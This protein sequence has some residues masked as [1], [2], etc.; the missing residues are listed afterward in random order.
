[1][2][3]AGTR[4]LAAHV[5]PQA[6]PALAVGS[7]KPKG[8]VL[9]LPPLL[10]TWDP[11]REAEGSID[12][13]SL[14]PIYDRLADRILP[15]L[16][17]RMRRIRFVTAMCVAASV[18][19]SD[20]ED[21][22]VAKDEVTPPWLVF[23]WFVVE[24]LVRMEKDLDDAAGVPGA[25]KVRSALLQGRPVSHPSYLKTPRVFGFS[26]IFRRF[27]TAVG[28][29]TDDLSLDDGGYALLRAWEKD[30]DLSGFRDGTKATPG[31]RLREDLRSAVRAGM[32]QGTTVR[33][34]REFWSTLARVLEPGRIKR[35]ER[36]VLLARLGTS[37]RGP[38]GG[39]ADELVRAL[40][41]RGKQLDRTEE[42]TF[43][44]SV[45]RTASADLACCLRALDSF[46]T[47]CRPVVD[48]FDLLRAL[49]T[50]S[51]RHLI[52]AAD[53]AKHRLAN[54]LAARIASG[55]RRVE[56]DAQLGTWEPQAL[57][58][59][60]TFSRVGTARALFDT[61]L[62]H[63]ELAQRAKPPDGKR[64]WFERT[65]DQASIRTAYAIGW[66]PTLDNT[67]VHQYRVPT[68]SRILAELGEL[69]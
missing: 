35:H 14:S 45:T 5:R 47:L 63:H 48:L 16:T 19:A 22:A 26:G 9:L 52:G 69:S 54:K 53:L 23:E 6:D 34:G 29:L 33:Q 44:R 25:T 24:A 57:N 55:V 59:A 67:Y 61:V 28:V 41:K 18:C 68:L 11:V 50:Q 39:H 12:P 21:G 31:G 38:R 27:V 66:S 8:C 3:D 13:L 37:A 42:G 51:D 20:Y 64:A 62:Q 10:S 36:I 60:R 32:N 1:M 49:S 15:A 2:T 56:E 43:L 58:L 4:G 65:K 30:L 40:R 17:V 46:E 7:V